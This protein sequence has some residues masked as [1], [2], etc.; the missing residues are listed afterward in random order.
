M[1]FTV[2]LLFLDVKVFLDSLATLPGFLVARSWSRRAARLAFVRPDSFGA[3]C[4][5]IINL[6]PTCQNV[7]A[8]SDCERSRVSPSLTA[9]VCLWLSRLT[10]RRYKAARSIKHEP[11]HISLAGLGRVCNSQARRVSIATIPLCR[12]A[13]T[14]VEWLESTSRLQVIVPSR[15]LEEHSDSGLSQP[16]THRPSLVQIWVSPQSSLDTCRVLTGD[17][18]ACVCR[19]ELQ[20]IGRSLERITD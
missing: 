16:L 11:R 6:D 7:P 13:L 18:F 5:I 14:F 15:I 4:P 19:N 8:S 2:C 17:V 20:K 12:L 10:L 9:S 3:R 1:S